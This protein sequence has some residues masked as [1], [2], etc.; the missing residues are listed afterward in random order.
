MEKVDYPELSAI[1]LAAG[2]STRMGQQKMLMPWGDTTVLGQVVR[3]LRTAGMGQIV[4]VMNPEIISK[5][6]TQQ[7][8]IVIN[9]NGEMLSSIQLGLQAQN[10]LAQAA[11]IC[12]GDQPQVEEGSVRSICAAFQ[13][14]GSRLIVPSYQMRRGHPWLVGRTL[15]DEILEM[16]EDQSMREFM[17]THSDEIQYVKVD[18][19]GVLQDL[20]TP[21]DYLKY[22]P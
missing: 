9:N 1:V 7:L 13:K 10:E 11:L 19:A 16:N 5:I 6:D 4:L 20:D 2:K 12:L 3:T 8:Q 17:N 15:W 21:E 18:S 14:G 22:K